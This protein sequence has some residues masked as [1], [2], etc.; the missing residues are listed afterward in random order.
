[1]N[2]LEEEKG[3]TH[4]RVEELPAEEKEVLLPKSASVDTFFALESDSKSLLEVLAIE[5]DLCAHID[6]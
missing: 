5:R 4:L 6:Y 1:M 2:K 3:G